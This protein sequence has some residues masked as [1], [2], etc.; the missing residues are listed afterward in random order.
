SARRRVAPRIKVTAGNPTLTEAKIAIAG[1]FVAAED[2]LS[3]PRH[4]LISGSYDALTGELTLSGKAT[5]A[6]YQ[7]ALRAVRY[8][9]TSHNP[10]TNLR[11]ISFKVSDGIPGNPWSNAVT[12]SIEVRP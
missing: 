5:V 7:W 3:I 6:Q 8:S 12:R 4:R 2:L 9:N 11:T 10:S 1:N